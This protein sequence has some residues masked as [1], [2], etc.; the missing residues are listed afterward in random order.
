MIELKNKSQFEKMKVA[1]RITGE[2]LAVGAAAVKPGVTTK[3]VDEVMILLQAVTG[4]DMYVE[5]LA[6]R[7]EGEPKTMDMHLKNMVERRENAAKAEDVI[8][9]METMGWDMDTTM[10]N[11]KVP[12]ENWS[13]IKTLVEEKL[14]AQ[15][16]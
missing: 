11:M 2:A 3:H 12:E 16:A 14:S 9:L 6:F 13:K 1:G 10:V 5:S 8:N 4:N 7:K 15:P